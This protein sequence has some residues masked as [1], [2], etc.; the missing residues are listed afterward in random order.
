MVA[1]DQFSRKQIPA[2]AHWC[3]NS[4]V[5]VAGF[6]AYQ[7]VFGSNPADLLGWGEGDGDLICV[8]DTSSPDQFAHQWKLRM[9]AQEA[10]LRELASFGA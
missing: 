8:R 3:L 10:G 4:L 1:G 9:M 6:S 2:G 5:S 7:L